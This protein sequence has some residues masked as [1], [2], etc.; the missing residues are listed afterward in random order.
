M[1]TASE[2]IAAIRSKIE[3]AD[4]HIGDLTT[5]IAA[6]SE[7]KPHGTAFQ[8]DPNTG[9]KIIYMRVFEQLPKVFGVIASDAIHNLRTALDHL[10]WQLVESNGGIPD[11]RTCFPISKSLAKHEEAVDSPKVEGF[12]PESIRI[13]NSIK[14]YFGGNG[15]LWS[16]SGTDNFDKHRLLLLTTLAVSGVKISRPKGGIGSAF[17]VANYNPEAFLVDCAE[18]GRFTVPFDDNDKVDFN[19]TTR[20]S[21]VQPEIVKGDA[22]VP[23]LNQFRAL[24]SDVVDMFASQLK[25]SV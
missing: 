18:L 13:L 5:A 8:I 19:I 16:L 6:F 2:R 22:V 9:E 23:L 11:W 4:K 7:R 15:G 12:S 24:V 25:D 21:F 20:V 10:A 17:V 3:R 14:P 1:P